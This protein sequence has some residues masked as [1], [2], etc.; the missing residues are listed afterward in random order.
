MIWKRKRC[1]SLSW[2]SW[3][4]HVSLY[5][6]WTNFFNL[7]IIKVPHK[8]KE[9]NEPP[10]LSKNHGFTRS[11]WKACIARMPHLKDFFWRRADEDHVEANPPFLFIF[12]ESSSEDVLFDY[13]SY[14]TPFL[15]HKDG[16]GIILHPW[17]FWKWKWKELKCHGKIQ[18][19]VES[20]NNQSF[21]NWVA[22]ILSD[23]NNSK[24]TKKVGLRKALNIAW[25]ISKYKA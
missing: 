5:F 6:F 3:I 21:D 25:S 4:S 13:H 19:R 24:V 17:L 18:I 16:E 8:S 7:T 9:A 14:M 20:Q 1:L 11:N 22:R 23:T 2:T 12:Y 10:Y 15:D